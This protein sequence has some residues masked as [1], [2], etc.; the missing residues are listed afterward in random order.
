MRLFLT[1]L[2]WSASRSPSTPSSALYAIRSTVPIACQMVCW[3]QSV[4]LSNSTSASWNVGLRQ[5][6]NLL[7]SKGECLISSHSSVSIKNVGKFWNMRSTWPTRKSAMGWITSQNGWSKKRYIKKASRFG[8]DIS[9]K[10][11]PRIWR[12][13]EICSKKRMFVDSR[14]GNRQ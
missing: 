12:L 4:L 6:P 10:K 1:S 11:M 5:L 13:S 3:T 9:L 8:C 7:K 14:N 2:V